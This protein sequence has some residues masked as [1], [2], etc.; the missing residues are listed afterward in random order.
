LDFGN[1]VRRR[2]EDGFDRV[3]AV[4]VEG[5]FFLLQALLPVLA[6]P[7]SVIITASNSGHGG[8]AGGSAYAASKAALSSLA[9]SWAADL[10]A[11]GVRVNAIS[12]GPVATPLFDKLGIPAEHHD[13]AMRDIAAT[14]P[15]GRFAT[16]SEIAKAVVFLASD[17]GSFAVGTD[18]VIDGGVTTLNGVT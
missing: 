4:N 16:P 1:E 2:T 15:V 12:P 14:I 17:E 11:A 5:T 18:L 3:F 6:H 7:S 8:F 13:G 10:L 9:R